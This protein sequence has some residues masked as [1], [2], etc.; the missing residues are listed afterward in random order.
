VADRGGVSPQDTERLL[1]LY[2]AFVRGDLDAVVEFLDP[3]VEWHNPDYAVEPGLRKGPEQ[4]RA[5]LQLLHES[6][7]YEAFE[8]EEVTEVG[9]HLF[10]VI[11]A[12]A[13][14][15]GSGAPIDQRFFHV[16]RIRA[17]KAIS[18]QWF[19]RR[20]EALTAARAED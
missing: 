6:F 3:D 5:A 9:D 1:D 18:M 13:S 4:F 19:A 14:G 17:G 10:A 15:T 20:D 2:E 7:D 8:V 11:R 12:R 16:W